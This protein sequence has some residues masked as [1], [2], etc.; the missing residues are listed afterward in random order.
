MVAD[1][2]GMSEVVG[3]EVPENAVGMW[4]DDGKLV[5]N[6]E[7]ID[8]KEKLVTVW[9]HEQVGHHG[10]RQVF[11]KN[12]ALFNRFL[13]QAYTL[14][15]VK[16]QANVLKMAK[17]LGIFIGLDKAGK[18]TMKFKKAEKRLIAEEMLA[19]KA[20]TMKPVTK[21][22]ILKRFKAFL[23]KWLPQSSFYAN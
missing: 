23:A 8:S 15:S 7:R 17:K 22:G 20:E 14:F 1:R 19:R 12:T 18:P 10:L 2:D 4:T 21:T 5:I 6:A 13:D 3:F 9:M 16:E 11:G